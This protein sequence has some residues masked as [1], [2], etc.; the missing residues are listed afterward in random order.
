MEFALPRQKSLYQDKDCS[1]CK[2][3]KGFAWVVF[4]GEAVRKEL[5][6]SVS[7]YPKTVL[8]TKSIRKGRLHLSLL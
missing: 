5:W 4:A 1:V 7:A 3:G 2:P 8:I 6:I